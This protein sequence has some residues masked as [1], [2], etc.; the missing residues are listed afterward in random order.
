MIASPVR[1][2]LASSPACLNR[3]NNGTAVV[4]QKNQLQ[5]LATTGLLQGLPA[6][7]TVEKHPRWN[8][9]GDADVARPRRHPDSPDDIHGRVRAYL[10]VNCMHCHNPN[11]NASNS[12]LSLDSFR[13][14]NVKYGIC[15]EPVAAGRG[16]GNNAVRHR[17]RFCGRIDP[18][19]PRRIPPKPV[20][21]CRRW[22]APWCTAKRRPC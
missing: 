9:P 19:L 21:A 1:H 17:A 10:E 7:N 14:V 6:L 16:S 3:N 5:H 18:E 8:V 11:G 4:V 12:G 20:S 2:R 15:K 13:T 22:R